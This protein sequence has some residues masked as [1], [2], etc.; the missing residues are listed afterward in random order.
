[1]TVEETKRKKGKVMGQDQNRTG[2]KAEGTA[3]EHPKLCPLLIKE[4]KREGEKHELTW[5]VM[6]EHRWI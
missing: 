1:M 3:A 2:R 6:V 5:V 4:E